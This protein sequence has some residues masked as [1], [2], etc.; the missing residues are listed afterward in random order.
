MPQ[1]P[2]VP[3][4]NQPP[5]APPVNSPV[6]TESYPQLT[7]LD[8]FA[9]LFIVLH[10]FHRPAINIGNAFPPADTEA[11]Q[12][13]RRAYRFAQTVVEGKGR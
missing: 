8:A 7:A 6:N 4:V 5:N 1:P 10:Y 9:A 13:G 2:N 12:L 11:V 3:P